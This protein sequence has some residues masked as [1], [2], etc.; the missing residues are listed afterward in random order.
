MV[1]LLLET[2][3]SE[4]FKY[5]G[6]VLLSILALLIMIVIHEFG[7]YISGKIL[8]FKIKEFAIGFG[9]K[10]FK[11][12]NKKNGEVFSLR[13]I[14]LGGFCQF[15]GE[16]DEEETK[17][18]GS[19]ESMPA[20]KRIIVLF[21]GAFFNFLSCIIII[22]LVFT[23]FGQLSP[24]V[25]SINKDSYIGTNN[26]LLENDAII[27]IN[28]K[29]VNILSNDDLNNAFSKLE[30]EGIF[31]I[32]RDNKVMDVKIK[33]S[34][35]DDVNENGE[36]VLDENGNKITKYGIGITVSIKYVKLNFFRAIPRAIMYSFFIVYKIFVAIGML[37]TGKIALFKSTGGMGTIVKTMTESVSAGFGVFSYII[38]IISANLA[39]MNLLPIPSLDGSKILLTIVESITRK[40]LNRKVI[41][42]IDVLSI[43]TLLIIAIVSDI[44]QFL[45]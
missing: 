30:D 32:I 21:S 5:I 13:A 16:T 36:Y 11:I 19:F 25:S 31:T 24:V 23:F 27:S 37:F 38:C 10:L 34:N 43:L 6:Y 2:T 33:K 7:H 35:F 40:K 44:T 14:P 3:A 20:W 12:T 1:N 18:V 29:Y 39:V 45:S 41:A 28:G 15:L 42:I 17:Q 4:V 22:T 9:P 8:G 26:L